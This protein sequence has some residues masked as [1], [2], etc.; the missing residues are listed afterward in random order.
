MQ[1]WSH[2]L[3][4]CGVCDIIFRT[5]PRGSEFVRERIGNIPGDQQ[6]R[7]GF[8]GQAD[9]NIFLLGLVKRDGINPFIQ[10]GLPLEHTTLQGNGRSLTLTRH[11]QPV[12]ATITVFNS[13]MADIQARYTL[14]T[15]LFVAHADSEAIGWNRVLNSNLLGGRRHRTSFK[16]LS[17][18][19]TNKTV[20]PAS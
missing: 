18:F 6:V 3:V 1:R 19:T 2:W 20:T 13:V 5:E 15:H 9:R 17:A 11:L 10:F 12:T 8:I 16:K 14:E 4:P 7:T